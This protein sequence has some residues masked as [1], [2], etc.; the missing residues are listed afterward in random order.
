MPRASVVHCGRSP[1][2]PGRRRHGIFHKLVTLG[3]ERG[4][5]IRT[6]FNI[7]NLH[8]VNRNSTNGLEQTITAVRQLASTVCTASSAGTAAANVSAAPGRI[9]LRAACI[10]LSYRGVDGAER[11]RTADRKEAA[12]NG[13]AR[14]ALERARQRRA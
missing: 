12:D 2:P 10:R 11:K 3:T 7:D 5:A 14:E 4:G 8:L 6:R 13:G 1:P 9:L